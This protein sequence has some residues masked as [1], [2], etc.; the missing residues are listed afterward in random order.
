M[1][2]VVECNFC[3]GAGRVGRAV[4]DIIAEA[5]EWARVHYWPKQER[6]WAAQYVEM[7][8]E[9]ARYRAALVRSINKSDLPKEVEST[10]GEALIFGQEDRDQD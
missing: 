8:S 10:A 9:N 5:V 6:R 7:V 3:G 2:Q 4:E 1:N